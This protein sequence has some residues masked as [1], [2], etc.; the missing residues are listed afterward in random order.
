MTETQE[1]TKERFSQEAE[2]M[3]P[4]LYRIAQGIL[5]QQSDAQDAVQQGLLRAWEKRGT[6]RPA[7]FRPWVIRIVINQCHDIQRR[8]MRM[9]P[10]AEFPETPVCEPAFEP[11]DPALAAALFSLKESLRVPLLLRYM[12]GWD[13][14]EIAAALGMPASLVKNRLFRARRALQKRILKNR[15]EERAWESE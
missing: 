10:T 14:G 8:R 1:M 13:T 2:A 3:L 5:R 11:P 7:S 15:E 12:E 6:V 4:Q 9:I